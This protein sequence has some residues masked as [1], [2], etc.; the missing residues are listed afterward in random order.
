M[1]I[2]RLAAL[3]VLIAMPG[4]SA[5][6]SA[7]EM[8]SYQDFIKGEFKNMALSRDGKLMLGPRLDT[9]FDSG[10]QAIW[11]MTKAPDGATYVATGHR[12]KLYK[13]STRGEKTLVWSSSQPEIFALA[14]DASGIV[15]AGTSQMEKFTG[16]KMARLQNITIPRG[17]LSGH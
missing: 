11:A 7:W 1:N 6:S 15:Y 17:N 8:N 2:F 3:A 12:G 16:L 4:I 5:S 14:V 13:I 10:E 9:I